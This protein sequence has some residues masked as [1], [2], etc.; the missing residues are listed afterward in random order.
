M[1]FLGS[2]KFFAAVIHLVERTPN[3]TSNTLGL[4]MQAA[5]TH[6]KDDSLFGKNKVCFRFFLPDGDQEKFVNYYATMCIQPRQ[7]PSLST[8]KDFDY[9]IT[10][11][12]LEDFKASILPLFV[13]QVPKNPEVAV[14]ALKHFLETTTLDLSTVCQQFYSSLIF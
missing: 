7:P 3:P 6:I 5:V 8:Y 4:I 10:G 11:L 14:F 12:S 9:L 13:T 2:P 1:K